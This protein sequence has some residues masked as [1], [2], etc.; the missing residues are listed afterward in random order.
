V[1]T[2]TAKDLRL[3]TA[4]L[5]KEIRNGQTILITHRGKSVA[6]LAPAQ[7]IDNKPFNPIGFGLWRERKEMAKVDAWLGELREPRFRR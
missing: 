5:L 1:R 3:K 4:A 2:A 6:I 7:E